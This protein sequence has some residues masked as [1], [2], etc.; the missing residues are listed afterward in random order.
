LAGLVLMT[1]L[2]YRLQTEDEVRRQAEQLERLRLD[3]GQERSVVI[4]GDAPQAGTHWREGIMADGSDDSEIGAHLQ[5]W[6]SHMWLLLC[7]IRPID[8]I[9][10][11]GE[12]SFGD[13]C[14][15]REHNTLKRWSVPKIC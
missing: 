2:P 5:P 10:N 1:M 11:T 12:L 15:A 6:V 8:Q 13:P 9:Y 14:Y 3:F 4:G 7:D